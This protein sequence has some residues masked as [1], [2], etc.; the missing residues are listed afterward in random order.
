MTCI[1]LITLQNVGNAVIKWNSTEGMEGVVDKVKPQGP[2]LSCLNSKYRITFA[3]DI[4]E[5]PYWLGRCGL[6]YPE[7]HS[8][9]VMEI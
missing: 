4:Q 1:Q 9:Q 2:C 8:Y 7:L 3:I 6:Y 5:L